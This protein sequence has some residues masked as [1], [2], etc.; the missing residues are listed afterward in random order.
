MRQPKPAQRAV[1]DYVKEVVDAK[2]PFEVI[3]LQYYNPG[4]DMLE[5]ER[6]LETFSSFGKPVHI[7]EVAIPSSSEPIDN[8]WGQR[9][10][11]PWHG[12][13]WSELTQ[14]D[15]IEQ[16][17]TLAYSKPYIDAVTWWD[18]VD[19]GFL[20]HGGFLNEDLSEKP[21]YG[22]LKSLIAGWEGMA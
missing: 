4:R 10:R 11:F 17:Y 18:I 19:P 14:A 9:P 13:R 8:Q 21:S 22:R 7:T 1:H 5:I 2:V 16:F 15:W 3:G 6:S 20:P 12:E